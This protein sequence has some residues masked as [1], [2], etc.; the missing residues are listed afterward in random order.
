MADT[1]ISAMSA[2]GALDGS[3]LVPIVQGGANVRTTVTAIATGG[4]ITW[5]LYQAAIV[6]AGDTSDP[7]ATVIGSNLTGTPVWT[8]SSKGT[9]I[10][11]L[12]GVFLAAKTFATAKIVKGVVGGE[13]DCDISRVSNDV[14]RLRIFDDGDNLVDGCNPTFVQVY[15]YA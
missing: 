9:Y 11:T 4:A 1:K 5:K 14:L 13:S 12:A 3:E 6:Q 8:R 7:T 2:A 15:V 10:A